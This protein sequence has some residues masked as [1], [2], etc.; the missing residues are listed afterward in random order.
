M[1]HNELE[2]LSEDNHKQY[3]YLNPTDLRNVIIPANYEAC[4]LLFRGALGQKAPLIKFTDFDGKE[5]ATIHADGMIKGK[6]VVANDISTGSIKSESLFTEKIDVSK[7]NV[8]SIKVEDINGRYPLAELDSL[9]RHAKNTEIH[10][11]PEDI[12]HGQLINSG[13]RSHREIDEHLYRED[14]HYEKSQISHKE[15]QDKGRYTHEQIDDHICNSD[16]HFAIDDVS[17][18]LIKDLDKDDHKQYLHCEGY[19]PIKK[20]TVNENLVVKGP[21]VF[22]DKLDVASE[23]RS[24]SLSAGSIKTSGA[25][26][27]SAKIAGEAVIGDLNAS[28]VQAGIVEACEV[29]VKGDLK[30]KGVIHGHVTSEEYEDHKLN[31]RREAHKCF[32]H[33]NSGFVPAPHGESTDYTFLTS[34]G[35]WLTLN[36]YCEL[37]YEGSLQD[38]IHDK[39]TKWKYTRDCV[40]IPLDGVYEI[41]LTNISHVEVNEELISKSRNLGSTRFL[42]DLSKG[43]NLKITGTSETG[44]LYIKRI[45][46]ARKTTCKKTRIY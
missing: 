28:Q 32:T 15:I 46:H 12:N 17:H 44:V 19:R 29:Q 7:L 45:D 11:K 27:G 25:S 34:T 43:D 33:N 21:A 2:G 39:T 26:F 35:K 36:Q 10:I 6:K 37:T 4:P 8:T 40:V 5:Q 41:S 1:R 23:V 13:E 42:L 18:G 14:I 38:P 20:L 30:V 24:G 22:S 3:I 31:K 16:H 9:N